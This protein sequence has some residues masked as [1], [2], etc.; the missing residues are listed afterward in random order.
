MADEFKK[1]DIEIL[2]STMNRNSLDFLIPMFP[3]ENFTS[4]NILVVNQTTPENLLISSFSNIKIINSYETGLSKSRNLALKNATKE[5]IIIADDDVVYLSEFDQEIIDSFNQNTE[6]SVICFQ[7]KTTDNKPFSVYEKQSFWM[8]KKNVIWVLSIE[9]AMKRNQI[10]NFNVEFNTF[11]GLGAKFQDSESF[12][13]LRRAIQSNLKILFSPKYIVKHKKYSSSD[14]VTSDR[15]L[16]A[17]SAG[18][19]K[20]SKSLSYILLFKLLFFLLRKKYISFGEIN[21]KASIGLKGIRDY[22]SLLNSN[23]ENY[24]N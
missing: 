20:K 10:K 17:K 24:N 13:F 16:Y 18:F 2:V 7:T 4:F 3:F 1:S 22:K 15:W 21:H 9:I 8:N 5:I 19:Y 12:F 14:E 6:A 23:L 11:F